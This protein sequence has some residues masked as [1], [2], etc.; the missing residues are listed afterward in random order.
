MEVLLE[1]GVSA[2]DKELCLA[3]WA[4]TEPGSWLHKVAEIGPSNHVLRTVKE[5]SRAALLTYLCRDCGVPATVTTRSEMAALGLW[6]PDRFPHSEVTSSSLC[7]ECREAATARQLEEKQRAEEERHNAEREQVENAS[8]W[9]ADHRSHPFPEEF[10]SVPD[11][12]S[13][14]TMIDIMVRTERDSFGP[15][16]TTK[17]T[18]G[19][20][21]S[22]DIETLRNLHRQRWLAPTL[23]ATIGDFAFNDDNTVRGVYADQVPWRLPHAFGD[24]ASH[25]LQEAS[26]SIQHLLLKRP[27]RL[28]DTVMELEA[29]TAL[30]YLDGLLDRSYGEPPVPEHRRQ[31]AYDTFH[32]ALVNGF[33]LRQLIAV[34]WMAASSSV[35]W[36][37]RTAGLKPGSVS[38]ACVTSI[39]RRIEAAH[40]RPVPEYDLPNWVS[41]PA[42]HATAQR[43]LK[44]HDA[45]AETLGQFRA[46]RQRIITRDLENLENLEFAPY[47]AGQDTGSGE[48]EVT[49]AVITPDGQLDFQSEFPGDMRE[50][51]C[52]A[53]GAVDRIILREPHTIH[54]YVGELI[55][56]APEI[57]NPVAN[58][59]LR[60]LDYHDGPFYGPVA[61]F[62]V[63]AGSNV[64]QSLDT[65]QQELLSLA[66]R[67]AATRVQSSASHT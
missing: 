26:E 36:G 2:E 45:V 7:T 15:I 29:I 13:L 35:A 49:F 24:D 61:F 50:K 20:S 44:Q 62:S 25:A 37:Q 5:S 18:L 16:N 14:L 56:P 4:F 64:P 66:H 65:Q 1:P 52:S 23:P 46:L 58:E 12:L 41:L 19:I 9:L 51:V 47:L 67:V 42:S 34:A 22:T 17:Y 21:R 43:L 27:S 11:A 54:A 28:R 32:E 63:S 8:T 55:T 10:P 6:R 59:T 40:D 39:G 30:A 53:G 3:Y 33:N 48:T 57:G 38:A 60:L 31:E